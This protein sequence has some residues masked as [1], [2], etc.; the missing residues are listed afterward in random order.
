MAVTLTGV[1]GP[2]G[3]FLSLGNIQ[4]R[5][6]DVAL[7][8]SYPSGGYAITPSSLALTN[9]LGIKVIGGNPAAAVLKY[10]WDTT[11]GKLICLYPTGGGNASPAAL[12]DPSGTVA[13]A[14]IPAGATAVTSTAANGAIVTV[15][16]PTLTPGRAKE[17]AAGTDLSSITVRLL[18]F[19]Y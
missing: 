15:P 5:V 11:N 6:Y 13:N 10:H 3:P 19:G 14:T 12:S 18:A 1:Q 9:I 7:D 17:V 16:N 4:G 8:T 2:Q